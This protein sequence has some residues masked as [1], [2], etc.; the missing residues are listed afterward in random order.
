MFVESVDAGL[1]DLSING[2]WCAA[3]ANAPDAFAID[4]YRQPS[5]DTDEPARAHGERLS[6]HLVVGDLAAI[7]CRLAGSGGCQRGAAC[8]GLSDQGV[9]SAAVGHTLEGHQMAA[10]VYDADANH[11]FQLLRFFD[12]GIDM[13]SQPS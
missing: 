12:G 1:P 13:M 3:A 9:V 8:V 11:L 10:R 5:F 6:Q 4:G 7:A 2:G